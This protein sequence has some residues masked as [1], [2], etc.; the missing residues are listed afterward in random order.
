MYKYKKATNI[1]KLHHWHINTSQGASKI[2]PKPFRILELEQEAGQRNFKC[3]VF[4]CCCF[5]FLL[6]NFSSKLRLLFKQNHNTIS[7]VY[8]RPYDNKMYY[9]FSCFPG[10]TFESNGGEGEKKKFKMPLKKQ[11]K[12]S[13]I[14]TILYIHIYICIH[15]F[16]ISKTGK[17]VELSLKGKGY[18]K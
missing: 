13:K 1:N 6:Y 10:N 18:K 9:F 16:I 8:V 7:F 2:I 14:R 12:S 3:F 5:F 15:L 11:N 17:N 4:F